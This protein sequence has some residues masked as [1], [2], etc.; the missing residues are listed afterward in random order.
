MKKLLLFPIVA[1][2]LLVVLLL[3]GQTP[4][5]SQKSIGKQAIWAHKRAETKL[6]GVT[7]SEDFALENARQKTCLR[8]INQDL[9]ETLDPESPFYIRDKDYVIVANGL[10][11]EGYFAGATRDRAS[12]MEQIAKRLSRQSSALLDRSSSRSS[13]VIARSLRAH[14]GLLVAYKKAPLFDFCEAQKLPLEQLVDRLDQFSA[15]WNEWR[16][17]H[18]NQE[19]L[20]LSG[21]KRLLDTGISFRLVRN[22][23]DYL[24]EALHRKNL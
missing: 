21:F 10:F 14:G 3:A 7:F 8:A 20:I 18:K 12:R 2:A 6:L 4:A 19:K 9:Q 24:V 11:R 13:R 5:A 15:E 1:V 17:L 16:R 23:P 22:Y